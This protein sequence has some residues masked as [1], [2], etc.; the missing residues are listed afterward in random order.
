MNCV[1]DAAGDS[2]EKPAAGTSVG[3][4]ALVCAVEARSVRCVAD[5]TDRGLYFSPERYEQF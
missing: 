5:G 2:F 4:G 3:I 1:S